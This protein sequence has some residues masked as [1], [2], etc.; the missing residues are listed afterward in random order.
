[1]GLEI[2]LERG[3]FIMAFDVGDIVRKTTGTK[4]YQVVEVLV[5]SK[6][7]CKMY[8]RV[9]ESVIYVFDEVDLVLV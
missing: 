5:D 3:E 8:P 7:K 9:C 2:Y 4:K 1:V 6:Y